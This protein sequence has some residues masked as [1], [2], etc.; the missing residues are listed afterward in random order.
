MYIYIYVC[1]HPTVPY[2]GPSF[3]RNRPL[4]PFPQAPPEFENAAL[5]EAA[6]AATIAPAAMTAAG[7]KHDNDDDDDDD[8]DEEE[9]EEE[10]EDTE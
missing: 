6:P 3:S 7:K 2:H 9:E 8:D 5:P 4:Y 1:V 10:E